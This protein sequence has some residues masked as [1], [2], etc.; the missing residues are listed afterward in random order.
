MKKFA[1]VYE[2]TLEEPFW[3]WLEGARWEIENAVS[4]IILLI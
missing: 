1:P 4:M 2:K 3:V